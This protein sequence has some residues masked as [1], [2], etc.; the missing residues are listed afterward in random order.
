[1]KWMAAVDGKTL[2]HSYDIVAGFGIASR[3]VAIQVLQYADG[4][5]VGSLSLKK[6]LK[7]G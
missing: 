4:V 2:C 1:M 7:T 3:E 6:Q 5:V